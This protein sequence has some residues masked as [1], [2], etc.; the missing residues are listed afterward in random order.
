[1]QQPFVKDDKVSVEQHV[2][3]VAKALGT[4]ITV[5]GY[6]RFEKG[7]GIDYTYIYS[8]RSARTT[9]PKKSRS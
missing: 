2:A 7:E 3:N 4:T 8:S 9:S 6:I 5:N 1:M